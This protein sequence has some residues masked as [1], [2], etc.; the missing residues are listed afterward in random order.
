MLDWGP[1]CPHGGGK[2]RPSK[3]SPEPRGVRAITQT[4]L[5][6]LEFHQ[7]EHINWCVE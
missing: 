2:G 7:A 1:G 3:I 6:Q 4:V 5:S